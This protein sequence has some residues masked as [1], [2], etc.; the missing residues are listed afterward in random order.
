MYKNSVRMYSA[1]SSQLVDVEATDKGYSILSMNKKPVNSLSLEMIQDFNS[2]FDAL[3][4]DSNCRGVI[5]T[6]KL[7]IFCAGLDI[8]EMFQP[9]P[10]RLREFWISFQEMKLNLYSSPMVLI[11]AINGACPAGGCAIALS[12]DYR[13]MAE[14]KHTMGLNETLLGIAAPTW[15]CES[16]KLAV[17]HREAERM[18]S[19]GIMC[20]PEESL[21]VG[22][23]DQLVDP[24]EL[25]DTS[26]NVIEKW[27]K[28]AD[29]G[30]MQTKRQVREK[31]ISEFK[32]RRDEDL[33]AFLSAIQQSA[34]QKMLG[35]YLQSLKK[36]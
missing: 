33:K 21:K 30:R 27:L 9:K 24:S 25:I 22:M 35:M 11:A 23:V 18:L 13:I 34:T 7:P 36:K 2:K 16:L 3:E 15:L 20:R 31:F 10:D 32:E 14:G 5:V 1:V 4:R 12:C 17:G 6:S 19:L 29:V 8:M 26:K 28:I